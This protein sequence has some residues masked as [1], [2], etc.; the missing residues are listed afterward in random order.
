MDRSRVGAW[1][2]FDV[3]VLEWDDEFTVSPVEN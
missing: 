1:D 2:A 3:G